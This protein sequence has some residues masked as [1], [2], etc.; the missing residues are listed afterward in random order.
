MKHVRLL[1]SL[2][3]PALLLILV[4][5]GNN[6]SPNIYTNPTNTP[7]PTTS[8]T[9]A[10]IN[11]ASE[12][13]KGKSVTALTNDKGWTLYYFTPDTATTSNCT[14]A[15][16]TTWPPATSKSA[17]V[18]TTALPGMLGLQNNANG[19]QVTYQGHPLY[20]FK[21]DTGP[22]QTNGEG[23]ANNTWHVATI[24]LTMLGGSSPAPTPTS[25]SGGYNY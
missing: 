8:P 13:V 11:T 23:K 15:C 17:P 3:V 14:G 16:A 12:T 9:G 20:T 10:V 24:D 2:I 25:S 6:N 1:F 4:A 18:S 19:S 5:C 21:N 7:A 22:G